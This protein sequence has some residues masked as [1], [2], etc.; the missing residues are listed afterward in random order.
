MTD[1]DLERLHTGILTQHEA[2]ISQLDLAYRLY[3]VGE[4]A[5]S[6]TLAGAAEEVLGKL[7]PKIG[8]SKMKSGMELLAFRTGSSDLN[9]VRNWLKHDRDFDLP[10]GE[11]FH[12]AFSMMV[13][14]LNNAIRCEVDLA[15]SAS[16]MLQEVLSRF[17]EVESRLQ[18]GSQG[19]AT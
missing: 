4:Y 17:E 14:A 1:D 19:A 18:R 6:V 10:R 2:A 8:A 3:M 11:V 9:K 5:A 7:A 15:E 16:S 13:R 12:A